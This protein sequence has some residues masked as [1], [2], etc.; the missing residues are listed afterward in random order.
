MTA[1]EKIKRKSSF[2]NKIYY[3]LSKFM[4]LEFQLQA[5]L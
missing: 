4:A 5:E 1:C 2:V 3:Y